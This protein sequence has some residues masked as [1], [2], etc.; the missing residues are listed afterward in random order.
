M[1]ELS[2]IS[3]QEILGKD[4]TV[5]GSAEEP[6][7]LAKDVAEW[8]EYSKTSDGYYNVS[9]MLMGIDEDEKTTITIRNSEGKTY[10]QSFVTENG[11]YE[12]LMLSKKPIAKQ[13][14]SEVK[15]VLHQLRTKGGYINEYG[16]SNLLDNPDFLQELISESSRKLY[17][18]RKEKEALQVELDSSKEWYSIKRMEKLNPSEN[19]SWR[20]LKKESEKLGKETKKVFDHN[21]GEVNAYHISVWESLYF[22]SINY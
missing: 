4:F 17:E 16:L 15:K 19:F 10:K 2:I 21:Y 8:I 20:L 7:F 6:L 11:L 18:L 1:N 9:K 3:K 14:K 5:Y 22:D 12:V 13:F